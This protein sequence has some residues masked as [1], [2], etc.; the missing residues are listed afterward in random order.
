MQEWQP[1]ML[2]GVPSAFRNLKMSQQAGQHSFDTA[3]NE[4]SNSYTDSWIDEHH[5]LRR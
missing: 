3:I 1:R 4:M 5:G 2:D